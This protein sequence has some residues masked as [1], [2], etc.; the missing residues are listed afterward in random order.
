MSVGLTVTEAKSGTLRSWVKR[1]FGAEGIVETK[2]DV[3]HAIAGVWRPGLYFDD[4]VSQG[5]AVTPFDLRL[6]EQVLLL[7]V[8][9]LD[10]LLHFV[11]PSA[12]SLNVYSHKARELLI[13]S[14]TEIENQWASYL[15]MAGIPAPTRGFTTNDYVRLVSPLRLGEYEVALPRYASVAPVRPFHG[16]LA[17]QPTK[18]LG[19]YDAYNKTKHDRSSHF[20]SATISNCICAVAA[21][22]ALFATRFGPFR[23]F[24]G[25]GTLPAYVNQLFSMTLINCEPDT[26]YAPKVLL[27]PNQRHDLICFNSRDLVQLWTVDSLVL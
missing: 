11:E 2:C 5:L 22:L 3:G 15:K 10:E 1:T 24:N 7:L 14:C 12:T 25:A 21:N 26:F 9:R 27:P 18:S 19:W 20:A 23:L 4:E 17:A 13:L 6:A 8:Q 16:W